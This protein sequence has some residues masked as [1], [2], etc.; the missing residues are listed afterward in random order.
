MTIQELGAIGEYIGSILVQ[1][2]LRKVGIGEEIDRGEEAGEFMPTMDTAYPSRPIRLR[3]S[4]NRGS[5]RSSSK[6]GSFLRQDLAGRDVGRPTG[7]PPTGQNREGRQGRQRTE[8][9]SWIRRLDP[10]QEAR[11]ETGEG[12][13]G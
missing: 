1:F 10:V 13:S 11:H 8:E 7:W 12:E 6:M 9:N 4:W 2:Q 3:S 5:G